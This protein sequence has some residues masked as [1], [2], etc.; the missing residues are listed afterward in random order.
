MTITVADEIE[1]MINERIKRGTYQSADEVLAASL[2]LLEA[3]ENGRD[4]LRQEILR[5]VEDVHQGRFTA[6]QTEAELD[7]PS[8]EI[9]RQGQESRTAFGKQ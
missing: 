5:G 6:Y 4:A 8:E 2:R 1:E 9:I 7:A 3:Q